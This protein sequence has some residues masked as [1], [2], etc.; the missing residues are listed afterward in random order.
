MDSPMLA[1][2]QRLIFIS[3]V[4][5]LD[6]SLGADG[7]RERER[8]SRESVQSTRLDDDDDDDDDIYNIF[9]L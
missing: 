8:E 4:W 7:E 6:A 3:S 9:R 5:T 1:E 2:L